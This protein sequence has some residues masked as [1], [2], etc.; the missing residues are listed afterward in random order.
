M[1]FAKVIIVHTP[2]F[3]I[4]INEVLLKIFWD[5][6]CQPCSPSFNSSILVLKY[7]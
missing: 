2:S 3:T 7:G 5:I 1:M 4:E 6:I